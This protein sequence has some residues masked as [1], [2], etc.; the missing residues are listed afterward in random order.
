MI[1]VVTKMLYNMKD[2][3]CFISDKRFRQE[4]INKKDLDIK[5]SNFFEQE[6][7][8]MKEGF[9]EEMDFLEGSTSSGTTTV[10][11][12]PKPVISEESK[13]IGNELDALLNRDVIVRRGRN[14]RVF[15]KFITKE[16]FNDDEPLKR[17]PHHHDSKILSNQKSS[18]LKKRRRHYYDNPLDYYMKEVPGFENLS[19]SCLLNNKKYLLKSLRKVKTF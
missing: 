17:D 13:L 6:D 11:I 16:I 19:S 1:T 15:Y 12:S 9:D 2:H 3:G 14:N 10:G 8:K 18:L 5:K 4:N 7:K